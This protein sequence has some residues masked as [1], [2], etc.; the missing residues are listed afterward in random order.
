MKQMQNVVGESLSEFLD[1]ALAPYL[2]RKFKENEEAHKEIFRRLD[3]NDADHTEI[4]ARFDEN[5]KD[6]DKMF[7]SLERNRNEHDE[8]FVKQAET[9]KILRTHDKRL[10]HLESIPAS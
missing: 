9:D 6:H 5:D 4:F 10:K 1:E 3:A 8:V 7:R 2:D